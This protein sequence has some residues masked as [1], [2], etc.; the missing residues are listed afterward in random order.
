[1]L[2]AWGVQISSGHEPFSARPG[3]G[4]TSPRFI[5]FMLYVFVAEAGMACDV[6][7]AFVKDKDRH[8]APDD[9]YPPAPLLFFS[10]LAFCP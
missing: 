7:S 6:A 9:D 2:V 5:A 8:I 10:L 4:S 3:S 1:M